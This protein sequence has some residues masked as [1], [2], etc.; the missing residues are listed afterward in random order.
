MLVPTLPLTLLSLSLSQTPQ[1]SPPKVIRA[2]EPWVPWVLYHHP[3]LDCTQLRPGQRRCIWPGKLQLFVQPDGGH[4]SMTVWLDRAMKVHLPG[5]GTLWPHDI[6]VPGRALLSA[7]S[8]KPAIMLPK[9]RHTIKGRFTWASP[10][11]VLSLPHELAQIELFRMGD[12]I[13]HPRIDHNGLWLS[14]DRS[15]TE[16]QT[17]S[18]RGA[19]Y[20]KLS[21]GIPLRTTNRFE[22]NV[23]GRAREVNLGK[24]M[25]EGCWPTAIRSP[26]PVQVSS[27][28][29]VKVYLKPGN[30]I[31]EIDALLFEPRVSLPVPAQ[32]TTIFDGDEIWVFEPDNSFRAIELSGLPPVDP[33]RT[34]LP[35]AWRGARTFV[36]RSGQALKIKEVRRGEVFAPPNAIS[37]VRNLWLDFDGRGYTVVDRL[38]GQLHQGWRLNYV[39]K[40]VIGSVTRLSDSRDLLVTRAPDS[41][42]TGVELRRSQV[43]LQTALRLDDALSELDIVG[44]DHDVQKLSARI[45]GPPGWMLLD[46]GGVDRVEGSWLGSWQP[47]DVFFLVLLAIGAYRLFGPIAGLLAVLTLVLGHGQAS[48]VRWG[49]AHVL[50][51]AALIRAVGNQKWLGSVARLYQIG[52]SVALLVLLLHQ[53]ESQVRFALHPQVEKSESWLPFGG[54]A[55][56]REKLE[57]VAVSKISKPIS[58]PVWRGNSTPA[59]YTQNS[60]A[61][62]SLSQLDPHAIVQ[63]GPGIQNWAWNKWTLSWTDPVPK[64]HK[65]KLWWLPPFWGRLLSLISA[66]TAGL[67][68]W[69]LLGRPRTAQ[70]SAKAALALA[71]FAMPWSSQAQE[72]PSESMLNELKQR[73]IKQKQCEG[74]CVVISEAKLSLKGTTIELTAKADVQQ[75]AAWRLPRWSAPISIDQVSVDGSATEQL[76]KERDGT[77]A[78]R[79]SKGRHTVKLRAQLADRGVLTMSFEGSTPIRRLAFTSA[80]WSLEG[81]SRQGA[82]QRTLQLLKRDRSSKG[83]P[84]AKEISE[85]GLKSWYQVERHL[86]LA[87]P[88]ATRTVV[89]RSQT[90]RS[91]IL[92]VPLLPGE[93]ISGVRVKDNAALIEFARGTAEVTFQSR[94]PIASQLEIRAPEGRAWTETWT[95]QCSPIWSC[96]SA[97]LAPTHALDP[98]GQH[99]PTWAPWPGESLRLTVQRPKGVAGQ[100]ITLDDVTYEL[101]PGRRLLGARLALVL[102]SSQG[103]WHELKLPLEAALQSV[104]LNGE[105]QAVRPQKGVLALPL[106]LGKTEIELRWQQPWQQGVLQTIPRVD[107]GAP[108]VNVHVRWK[109]S[110]DRWLLWPH[111]PR[112]GPAVLFWMRL[113]LL[114]GLALVFARLRLQPLKTWEWTVLVLGL[115][116]VSPLWLIAIAGAFAALSQKPGMLP[117]PLFVLRQLGVAALGLVALSGLYL[118]VHANLLS[119]LDVQVHGVRSTAQMLEWYIDQVPGVVPPLGTYSAPLWGWRA[120]M[121]A[122]SLWLARKLFGWGPWAW[123]T[124]RSAP[125]AGTVDVADAGEGAHAQEGDA[126]EG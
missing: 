22:L 84:P 126:G 54:E 13:V 69:L 24:V 110:D 113:A 108:A 66:L 101:T 76:R 100:T 77:I 103:G 62:Q 7:D 71:F 91:E 75:N 16:E 53:V 56:Q 85:R 38:S 81:L 102:R 40:G 83:A 120:L 34:S 47:F 27:N 114:L 88:W 11:E 20:R 93:Q 31:V 95:V 121:L 72:F 15:T 9:G 79:L 21:D 117:K 90:E 98:S 14:A 92:P 97:G 5:D 125:S 50:I 29:E 35:A 109:L 74:P 86:S 37:L 25:L 104:K 23:S 17:E 18:L 89:R 12:R 57:Q 10:P 39:G 46:A 112:W 82:P 122:W 30:H 96:A 68:G 105:V 19:V 2:L 118:A 65:I 44:W 106:R 32:P 78:V 124:L 80:D 119:P 33:Q 59:A 123:R 49:W 42:A 60:A 51:A 63:T 8:E 70:R 3:E 111:G 116:Q 26:L 4:F 94:L 73:L 58:M 64:G 55:P 61:S 52:A 87:L 43:D 48:A 67:L 6:K 115:T 41:G 28:G 45:N 36:A 99:V 107:L 1:A